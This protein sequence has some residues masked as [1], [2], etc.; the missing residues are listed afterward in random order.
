VTIIDSKPVDEELASWFER[1]RMAAPPG[2]HPVFGTLVSPNRVHVIRR[3]DGAVLMRFQLPTYD[4]PLTT[5]ALL[6]FDGGYSRSCSNIEYTAS[7]VNFVPTV[8]LA[9]H[10][11]FQD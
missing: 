9:L 1:C 5:P 6:W 11:C 2:G 10:N 3:K 7:T 4:P 8:R